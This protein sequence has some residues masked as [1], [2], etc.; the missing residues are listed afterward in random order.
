MDNHR[1]ETQARRKQTA[2]CHH[3]SWAFCL[4]DTYTLAVV[5]GYSTFW[6]GKGHTGY[7][8][9][10]HLPLQLG[11]DRFAGFLGGG[12]RTT[13]PP[14]ASDLDR[15]VAQST[16]ALASVVAPRAGPRELTLRPPCM[17]QPSRTSPPSA[18]R[19]TAR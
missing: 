16:A 5:Q 14:L 13:A 4:S 3:L 11:F 9:F 19:A 18:G 2:L 6:F 10:Y 8:S 15:C 17:P 1:A 12:E 7:K